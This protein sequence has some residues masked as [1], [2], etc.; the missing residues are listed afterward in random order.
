MLKNNSATLPIR[1]DAKILVVG[2]AADSIQKICGG[3]TLS[4]QGTEITQDDIPHSSTIGEAIAEIVGAKNC[5]VD[6]DLSYADPV[7]FDMVIAAIGEDAYAEMRG[8]IR[9]W[10]SLS[11]AKLKTSYSRD[12]AILQKIR[13]QLSDANVR[14]RVATLFFGGRPLYVSEEINLSDAFVA[15]WLPG[16][17]SKALAALL[18]EAK[19]GELQYDFSG[20]LSF[21]WPKD[22][23]SFQLNHRPAALAA[24]NLAPFDDPMDAQTRALF[25]FGYGLSYASP[26]SDMGPVPVEEVDHSEIIPAAKVGLDI[27][28]DGMSDFDWMICGHN[29]WAGQRLNFQSG[30]NLLIVEIQPNIAEARILDLNFKGF[31]ALVYARFPDAM[32]RDFRPYIAASAFFEIDTDI[33]SPPEGPLYLALHDDYPG[34]PGFD[35]APMLCDH[36]PGAAILQ[37]PM[38]EI[39]AT[40]MELN[41]IDT[42]FM[43]YSESKAHLSIRSIKIK[44]PR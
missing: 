20:K 11:Y 19:N 36:G 35:I 17:Y 43:L 29:I 16:P 2:S 40:G 9:P 25:P 26:A 3:W 39:S 33:L 8:N 13:S 24:Q 42:A 44:L 27:F 1:Q 6:A 4:W 28:E 18:F 31:A 38:H 41:N 7:A 15:A 21:S 10:R 23:A 22:S 37:I 12:L 34:Q 5:T 30:I 14:T 32:P